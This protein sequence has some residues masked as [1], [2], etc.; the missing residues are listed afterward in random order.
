M[1]DK[2]RLML[3]VILMDHIMNSVPPGMTAP[4]WGEERH[5]RLGKWVDEMITST[6]QT[7]TTIGAMMELAEKIAYAKEVSLAA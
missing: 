6:G 2:E 7:A 3:V 1:T 4:P 5:E